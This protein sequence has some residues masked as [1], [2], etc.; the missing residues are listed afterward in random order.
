[1]IASAIETTA[2]T[3]V[4]A[5]STRLR[6]RKSSRRRSTAIGTASPAPSRKKGGQD[7][8]RG[9]LRPK[10]GSTTRRASSNVSA[11]REVPASRL[12]ARPPCRCSR[13]ML[14]RWTIAL[15]TPSE[16]TEIASSWK[17]STT[18]NMPNSAGGISRASTTIPPSS[19]ISIPIRYGTQ[20]RPV[21]APPS[22][23]RW[24]GRR[25]ITAGPGPQSSRTTRAGLP[26]GDHAGGDRGDDRLPAPITESAPIV[27]PL[28]IFTP[29]PTKTLSP[30][31]TG[32]ISCS[33][34]TRRAGSRSW[35]FESK[36]SMWAPKRPSRPTRMPGALALDHQVVVELG[37]VTELDTAPAGA[38]PRHGSSRCRTAA[39]SASRTGRG[40][41]AGP[42]RGRGRAPAGARPAARQSRGQVESTRYFHT[43]GRWASGSAARVAS[44]QPARRAARGAAGGL[45]AP[46]EAVAR[47]GAL[48]GS[49]SSTCR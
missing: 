31:S 22:G 35:K 11:A 21:A 3:T 36:I 5:R 2:R 46:R 6:R 23:P 41:R 45:R 33:P 16:G 43:R 18:A 12:I 29:I 27:T 42:R 30:M 17:I 34:P 8:E 15:P 47:G 48:C 24:C 49:A 39:S 9:G 40:R 44:G 38:R 37:A 10:S 1:M 25:R 32:A 4:C 13:V 28:R 14:R 7:H 19:A 26:G 20:R